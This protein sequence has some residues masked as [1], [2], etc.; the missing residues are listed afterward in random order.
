MQHRRRAGG[1]LHVGL[2][3]A[4][5]VGS[6]AAPGAEF[7]STAGDPEPG[8]MMNNTINRIWLFL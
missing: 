1:G 4:L 6:S 8:F 5:P 7:Q 2:Q 3:G